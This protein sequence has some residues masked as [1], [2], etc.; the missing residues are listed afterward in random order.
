MDQT[1]YRS[2]PLLSHKW[3]IYL[4]IAIGLFTSV[5]DQGSVIVA[6]PTIS[7]HFAT[8][9]PTAQWVLVGYS[10]SISALL[11]PMG[12][13]SDIVGRK[14]VYLSGFGLFAVSAVLAASAGS[15]ALL[16]GARVLMGVGSAMVQGTSM[17]I[18]VSTF[19]EAER[20]KALG[21]QMSA[22]GSGGV[23]G[24]VMGGLIVGAVGWQGVFLATAVLGLISFVAGQVVLTGRPQGSETVRGGF[25]WLGAGLSSLVLITFLLAVSNGATL[26]WTSPA[27]LIASVAVVALLVAFTWWELVSSN[28]MLDLRLFKRPLFAFG[29]LAR[30]GSFLGISPVRFLM[31]FYLQAVRGYTP[32]QVGLVVVPSAAAFILTG[33]LGGRLSDRFGWRV[34]SV[35]GLML[36]ALGLLVLSRVSELTPLGLVV[37]AMVVQSVGS[38]I[39]GA[40]NSSAVLSAV[41]REEYGVASGFLNLVRNAGNVTGIAVATA[42]VTAVMSSYGVAP[43]LAEVAERTAPQ[44][45]TAFVSGLRF[46]YLSAV[47]IVLLGAF[48]SISLKGSQSS[49]F[50]RVL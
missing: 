25:D 50:E 4:A 8:D 41:E 29:A 43:S 47:A 24:P 38:G 27:I 9:L 36:S 12:R 23:A 39:F 32:G 1:C 31:P 42:V 44:A 10:L 20:G 28:P 26:G 18:V 30:F 2:L 49:S 17:A 40:P 48:L 34:P 3:W 33:P 6:L 22:V 15:I 14:R 35:S 46:A 37:A 13:L 7:D 11:L 45:I 16:V 21:L 19:P 5:A